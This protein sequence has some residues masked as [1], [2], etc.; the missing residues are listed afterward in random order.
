M[1]TLG[2]LRV[3][4]K[5][6]RVNVYSFMPLLE[7]SQ[8]FGR[9][10][11]K[12]APTTFFCRW[13]CCCRCCCCNTRPRRLRS[14]GRYSSRERRID[15]WPTAIALVKSS[16]HLLFLQFPAFCPVFGPSSTQLLLLPS[17]RCLCEFHF[18]LRRKTRLADFSSFRSSSDDISRARFVVSIQGQGTFWHG[19]CMGIATAVQIRRLY[20]IVTRIFRSFVRATSSIQSIFRVFP[21]SFLFLLIF[22]SVGVFLPLTTSPIN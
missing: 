8:R 11:N 16:N 1:Y 10:K 12:S 15:T 22:L 6:L 5:C 9:R 20:A 18:R 14:A 3:G 13:C 4:C 2:P 21:A 17:Q 7:N 19:I